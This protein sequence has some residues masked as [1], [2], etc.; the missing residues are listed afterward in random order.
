MPIGFEH[1]VTC[2]RYRKGKADRISYY[3][4]ELC[5]AIDVWNTI[6]TNVGDMSTTG[7]KI[8]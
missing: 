1:G 2:S 5:N 6:E 3:R 4:R 7:I 8:Y